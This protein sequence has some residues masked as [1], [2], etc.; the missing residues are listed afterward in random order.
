MVGKLRQQEPDTADVNLSMVGKQSPRNAGTL[1]VF[2]ILFSPIPLPVEEN[3][4]ELGLL[5]H[6][7]CTSANNTI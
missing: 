1:L 4:P 2:T 6:S 7:Y 5:A 3:Y